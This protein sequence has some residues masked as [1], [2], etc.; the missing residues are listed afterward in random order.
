[1]LS[2]V[3]RSQ[4]LPLHAESFD[5]LYVFRIAA[6]TVPI[7]IGGK[8]RIVLVAEFDGFLEPF[9]RLLFIALK[10]VDRGEPVCDVVIGR[11]RGYTFRRDESARLFAL[12]RF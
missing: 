9:D 8:P 2:A 7:G 11:C 3:L 1:R 4:L 6:Q 5:D 12:A 10:S